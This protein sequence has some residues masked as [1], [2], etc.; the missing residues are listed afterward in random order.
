MVAF[1]K[2]EIGN[3]LTIEKRMPGTNSRA[4]TAAE[5]WK[6]RQEELPECVETLVLLLAKLVC[7]LLVL[8]A[9][10]SAGG[11]LF[12]F[13]F[14]SP[15]L[16]YTQTEICYEPQPGCYVRNMTYELV[17][18]EFCFHRFIYEFTVGDNPTIFTFY[19]LE[20]VKSTDNCSAEEGLEPAKLPIGNTTCLRPSSV[21]VLDQIACSKPSR[22]CYLLFLDDLPTLNLQGWL[23]IITFAIGGIGCM[24]FGI[25]GCCGVLVLE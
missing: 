10:G 3:S 9:L 12:Y 4:L 17:A 5:R 18:G 25:M 7:A 20:L 19:D 24:C 23:S 21:C 16:I 6:E 2:G 8:A 1:N 22:P 11:A 15:S 14:L 13:R